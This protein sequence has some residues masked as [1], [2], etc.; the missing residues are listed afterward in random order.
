[1]SDDSKTKEGGGITDAEAER[2]RVAD[3]LISKK[4]ATSSLFALG[5]GGAISTV[6]IG[7]AHV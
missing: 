1:M 7:R 4:N 5:I 2:A 3:P 6:E